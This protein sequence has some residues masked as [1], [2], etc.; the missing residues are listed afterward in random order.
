[1]NLEIVLAVQRE[2]ESRVAETDALR[3]QHVER[4][5]YETEL[6]RRRYMKVKLRPTTKNAPRNNRRF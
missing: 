6:A 5:R 4:A 1:M 3:R 2:L